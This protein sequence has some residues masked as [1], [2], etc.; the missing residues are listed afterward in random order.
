MFVSTPNS[1]QSVISP[2]EGSWVLLTCSIKPPTKLFTLK[3]Q[4]RRQFVSGGRLGWGIVF[5][6]SLELSDW[7]FP[8][9]APLLV[10][11]TSGASEHYSVVGRFWWIVPHSRD[12]GGSCYRVSDDGTIQEPGK[13]SSRRL[14]T[15]QFEKTNLKRSLS[16]IKVQGNRRR[17]YFDD[18]EF[19]YIVHIVFNEHYRSF[20]GCTVIISNWKFTT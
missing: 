20:L 11:R 8:Q 12:G 6:G 9:R 19:I 15:L 14:P 13:K 3:I 5:S 2:E 10:P 7:K 4:V 18:F 1:I 16:I 17:Q